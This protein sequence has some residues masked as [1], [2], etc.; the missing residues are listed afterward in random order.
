VVD[1]A[2]RGI[3]SIRWVSKS[4]FKGKDLREKG[5]GGDVRVFS[6]SG[7]PSIGEVFMS[8]FYKR[9]HLS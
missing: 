2:I 9:P 7:G 3:Y 8:F 6:P 1:I 5:V 4:S